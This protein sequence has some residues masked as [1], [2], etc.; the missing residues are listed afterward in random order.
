MI[1]SNMYTKIKTRPRKYLSYRRIRETIEMTSL[2]EV[3]GIDEDGYV[4]RPKSYFKVI[5]INGVDMN[6]CSNVIK[7]MRFN[8]FAFCLNRLEQPIKIISLLAPNSYQE[9]ID[10]INK[11]IEQQSNPKLISIL[12]RTKEDYMYSETNLYVLKYFI[13]VYGDTKESVDA[14]VDTFF[15]LEEDGVK[16][17]VLNKKEIERLFFIWLTKGGINVE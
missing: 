16:M 13:F 12:E 11:K 8:N 7:E 9:Q 10:F 6:Y 2:L 17:R 4:K 1:F 14:S 3:I 5:E 15:H